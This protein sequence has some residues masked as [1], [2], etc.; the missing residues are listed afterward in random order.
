MWVRLNDNPL[1]IGLSVHFARKNT[2]AALT[3]R[4]AVIAVAGL[5]LLVVAGIL[6]SMP[7]V[8]MALGSSSFDAFDEGL[9]IPRKSS[10]APVAAAMSGVLA[11]LMA[12][13]GPM[14]HR[15]SHAIS[16]GDRTMTAPCAHTAARRR[17]R[18]EAPDDGDADQRHMTTVTILALRSASHP[19]RRRALLCLGST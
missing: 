7:F 10:G 2:S 19:A 11:L 1:R 13:S 16:P 12:V 17:T 9:L 5:A 4:V 18:R 8:H 15:V 6:H 3:R 14:R